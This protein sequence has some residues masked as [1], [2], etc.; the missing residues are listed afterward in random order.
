MER[1]KVKRLKVERLKVE[2]M[3]E[4]LQVER[5]PALGCYTAGEIQSPQ[6]LWVG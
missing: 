1:A 2:W 5:L 6:K 4:R 3:K